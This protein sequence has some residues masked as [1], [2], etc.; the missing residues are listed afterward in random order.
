VVLDVPFANAD[1]PER[2]EGTRQAAHRAW[3]HG[4]DAARPCRDVS[5]TSD[6]SDNG[7]DGNTVDD[8]VIVDS[9][10]FRLRAERKES[11]TGRIYT[12]TYRVT[13]D[14]GTSRLGRPRSW[15]Q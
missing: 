10:T 4:G 12:V 3:R 11:G 7:D 14:C 15:C 2:Y 9:E 5:V 13:D 8:T 6:E 1:Y